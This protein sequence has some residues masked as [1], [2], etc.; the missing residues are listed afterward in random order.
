MSP[1]S[2]SRGPTPDVNQSMEVDSN[3]VS[4]LPVESFPA[5]FDLPVEADLETLE[6]VFGCLATSVARSGSSVA[7]IA[8]QHHDDATGFVRDKQKDVFLDEDDCLRRFED[9]LSS[10]DLDMDVIWSR[11][12]PRCLSSNLRNRLNKF[13]RASGGGSHDTWSALKCAISGG[14]GVPKEQLRVARIR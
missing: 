12:L 6:G 9:V 2:V 3:A 8:T 1:N 14:Y 5:A 13:L 11:L 4:G 7:S 10:H